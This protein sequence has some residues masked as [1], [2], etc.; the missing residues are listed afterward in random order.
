V[1]RDEIGSGKD[2]VEGSRLYAHASDVFSGDERIEADDFHPE[3]GGALGDDPTDVAETDDPDGLIAHFNA[4]ELI[5]V[6]FTALQR[7]D[8]LGNVAR[9]RHHQS[10]RMLAGGH[11]VAARRVHHDDALFCR[12]IRVDV[13]VAHTSA[14][15]HFEIFS[16]FDQVGGNLGA[17]AD[18]PTVIRMANFFE[19][20]GFESD[21]DIDFE[22][23][24]VFENFQTFR[25]ERVGD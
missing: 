24:G 4:D 23:F 2:I 15:D 5:A 20:V 21:F 18:Y 1:N 19:L 8:G 22:S 11:I 13:L 3:C 14:A 12:S 6:P 10:D 16:G 17:A 9:Q 7:R 25:G